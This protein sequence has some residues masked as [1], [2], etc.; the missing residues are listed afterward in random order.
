MKN[1]LTLIIVVVFLSACG[2]KVVNQKQLQNLNIVTIE[3]FGDK[4]MN[5]IIK[6]KLQTNSTNNDKQQIF[7]KLTTNKKKS[8]KEKNI[9]NEVTKYEINISTNVEFKIIDKLKSFKF[10]LNETG[11]YSVSNQYSQTL[12][13]EKQ[14]IKT[15][16]ENISNQILEDLKSKLNDL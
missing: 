2:F 11:S 9:K 8:I 4:R 7:L 5:F 6:N 10:R 16:A 12:N 14:L 13:N 3:T 15:L 1:I